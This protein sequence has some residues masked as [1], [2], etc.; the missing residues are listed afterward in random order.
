[1]VQT[2]D[3]AARWFDACLTAIT[4][5]S[6]ARSETTAI[7]DSLFGSTDNDGPHIVN[8]LAWPTKLRSGEAQ[9]AIHL[10]RLH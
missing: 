7:G 5:Q 2:G 10:C 3:H 1:M 9:A 4:Q 6:T 8:G